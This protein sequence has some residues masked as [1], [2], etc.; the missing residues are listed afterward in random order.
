MNIGPSGTEPSLAWV[1][2][3]YSNG[4]G[5]ECVECVTDGGRILLRDTKIADGHVTAVGAPA[6]RSFT[7]AV[8]RGWAEPR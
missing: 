3:S 6:W 2:S 7:H 4:A 1:R 8:R 5:G